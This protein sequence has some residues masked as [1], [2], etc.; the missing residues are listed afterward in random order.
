MALDL[1]SILYN[2]PEVKRPLEKRLSFNSKLKWTLIILGAFFILANISLYGLA[3]NSLE[4][5][6]F[7]AIILGTDFGSI[8]SLGIGPIVMSSIILQLLVGSGILNIDTKSPEGKRYF[9]GLQK[10]GVIFFIIFEAMVY[11]LMGG[12]QAAPGFT[13][14]VIFQ[15]ILGGFAILFMDEVVQKYGFGSGVSLFIVAGVAW[16]LFTALFQFMGIQ[17]ENCLLNFSNTPC[18]GNLLIIIQSIINGAPREALSS[19]IAIAVTIVIFLGVVWA[20]SL[21]IEVPLTYERVRGYSVKWP[22]AFFYAS[23]IPVILVSALIANL[24]LFGSL[25][26]SWLGHPT[27][28]GS[29][30]EG[31]AVS[32][33]A[34]WLGSSNIPEL[35]IRGG[36]TTSHIFQGIS[37]LLFFMIFAAIFSVFW[38]KTSGM[39]ESSQAKNILSSGL[40]LPGFRKDPRVLESILKRYILPLTIMGGLAIGFLAAIADSLGALT[41][42]TAIL[43]AVMIM[44]QLY[45]SIAQQH[46]VD[47]HPALR[48]IIE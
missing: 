36:L 35:L 32:G 9:Q 2:L 29:F 30:S 23:V 3:A 7:I 13:G 21:K 26:E 31:Q 24:Q 47:M 33:V 39:D 1:R 34:Y 10:I 4:R 46:A 45:Q 5:F 42:G 8:I 27:F 41:S 20:Q 17:G 43:L 22:L 6:E 44:Y 37:H 16:R 28:L 15:L 14:I 25:L 19:I 40:Q 12:L 18:A 48:K 38:V 11:V